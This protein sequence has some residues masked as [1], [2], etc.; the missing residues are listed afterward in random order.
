MDGSQIRDY[1]S[2]FLG[3]LSEYAIKK[4]NLLINLQRGIDEEMKV[5]LIVVGLPFAV[6]EK[7]DKAD[8][9]SDLLRKLNAFDRPTR[10]LDS[11]PKDLKNVSPSSSSSFNAFSLFKS[12]GFCSYCLKKGFR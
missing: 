4:E 8:V 10:N 2:I 11:S 9:P 1:L 5:Y 12:R 6:Q 7:I 3:S